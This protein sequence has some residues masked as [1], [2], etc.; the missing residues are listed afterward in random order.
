MRHLGDVDRVLTVG[1]LAFPYSRSG[2]DAGEVS[3]FGICH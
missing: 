1:N 2:F 3:N